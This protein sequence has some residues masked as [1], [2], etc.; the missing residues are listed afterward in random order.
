MLLVRSLLW[1][2]GPSQ[3]PCQG[4]GSTSMVDFSLHTGLTTGLITTSQ[5]KVS[6]MHSDTYTIVPRVQEEWQPM[7]NKYF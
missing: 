3:N 4:V 5:T 2:G 7:Y 1:K 6:S